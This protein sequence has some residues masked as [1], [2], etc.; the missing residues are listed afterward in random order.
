MN[1]GGHHHS[2]D[3]VSLMSVWC[4]AESDDRLCHKL[5]AVCPR[6]PEQ[7]PFKHLEVN[8]NEVNLTKK[9][10]AGKFGE[11]WKGTEVSRSFYRTMQCI[12]QTADSCL[13]VH[14][15]VC[16]ASTF[17]QKTLHV[18]CIVKILFVWSFQKRIPSMDSTIC[19]ALILTC[20]E[21]KGHCCLF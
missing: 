17:C 7:I 16:H 15:S 3:T 6:R 1:G 21:L 4:F 5:T 11:V 13:S 12:A 2:G 19:S 10:G 18:S 8:R 14:L 20:T 9:L